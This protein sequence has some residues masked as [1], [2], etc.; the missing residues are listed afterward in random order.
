M[1]VPYDRIRSRVNLDGIPCAMCHGVTVLPVIDHCHAHGA[2]RGVLCVSCNRRMARV[3]A[4][5]AIATPRDMFHRD[6]CPGCRAEGF[7]GVSRQL[8]RHP[9]VVAPR[10]VGA[11]A[12]KP[13]RIE[14]TLVPKDEQL[15]IVRELGP[16]VP[17][18]DIRERLGCSKAQ[19]SRLRSRIATE[20]GQRATRADLNSDTTTASSSDQDDEADRED[21]A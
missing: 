10:R 17:L 7:A 14:I 16:T 12:S 1:S 5:L 11:A 2:T 9:H 4:N 3:D 20:A 19:A 13:T 6:N 8:G 15:R 21:A 18:A